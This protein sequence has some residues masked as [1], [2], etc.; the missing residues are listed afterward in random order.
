MKPIASFALIAVLFG[1]TQ[2]ASV[3]FQYCN[4][5]CSGDS[6]TLSEYLHKSVHRDWP[7]AEKHMIPDPAEPDTLRCTYIFPELPGPQSDCDNLE[8]FC[9]LLAGVWG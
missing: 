5:T 6:D 4:K 1:T 2:A 9:K 7:E 8:L 3:W